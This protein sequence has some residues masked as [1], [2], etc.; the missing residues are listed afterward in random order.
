MTYE[1]RL[2]FNPLQWSKFETSFLLLILHELSISSH[3]NKKLD[4][5]ISVEIKL[6]YING[7]SRYQEE[8]IGLIEDFRGKSWTFKDISEYLISKGY[9]SS[10]DKELSPQLVHHMYKKYLRKIKRENYIQISMDKTSFK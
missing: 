7:L 6:S 2:K 9:R 4:L 3:K 8:V 1:R 10:R 5:D